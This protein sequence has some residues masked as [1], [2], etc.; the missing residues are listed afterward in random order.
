M[1]ND[2]KFREKKGNKFL[3][4]LL[5]QIKIN[6][7]K[8]R[9]LDSLSHRLFTKFKEKNPD[10]ERQLRQN[11]ETE[12]KLVKD[13]CNWL[14]REANNSLIT[15]EIGFNSLKDLYCK[16]YGYY[17]PFVTS[18]G[19]APKELLLKILETVELLKS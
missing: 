10:T 6:K 16:R 14:I 4:S 9:S 19:I 17:F 2:Q 13:L 15:G 8:N 7:R 18:T 1:K 12:S 3:S 5:Y 11:R